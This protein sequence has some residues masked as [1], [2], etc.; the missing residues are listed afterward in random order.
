MRNTQVFWVLTLCLFLSVRGTNAGEYGNLNTVDLRDD[1]DWWSEI[2]KDLG[3]EPP[4]KF[5]SVSPDPLS[6]EILG[7]SVRG[8]P[9][10]WPLEIVSV[11]GRATVVGRGDAAT[12]RDQICYESATSSAPTKLIFETGE[13]TTSFY[14]FEDGAAFTGSDRC[15]VSKRVVRDLKTPSGLGLGLTREQVKKILGAPTRSDDE[16]ATYKSFVSLNRTKEQLEHITRDFPVAKYGR[17]D[18]QFDDM[19]SILIKFRNDSS[20]YLF[21]ASTTC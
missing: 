3:G 1:S 14:L 5:L 20:W 21:V 9:L 7:I 17:P 6:F 19:L 11:L 16:S 12:G 15:Q 13:C 18:L 10:H 2:R 4:G 8:Y